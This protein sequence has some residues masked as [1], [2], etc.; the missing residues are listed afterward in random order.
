MRKETLK[1]RFVKSKLRLRIGEKKKEEKK[2]SFS[3]RHT[4]SCSS[5]LRVTNLTF[6]RE[7]HILVTK[8]LW[9]GGQE[10]GYP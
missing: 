10:K 2:L 5:N 6:R 1:K 8:E 4:W 9:G 7:S 3:H